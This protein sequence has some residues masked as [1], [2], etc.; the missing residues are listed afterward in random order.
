LGVALGPLQNGLNASDQLLV[1][2]GLLDEV[3]GSATANSRTVFCAGG[4]IVRLS[5]FAVRKR[6]SAKAL[7]P[8]HEFRSRDP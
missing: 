2:N 7:A 1:V 8:A 3:R 5:D 6:P 4:E